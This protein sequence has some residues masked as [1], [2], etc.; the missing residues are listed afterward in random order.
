MCVC[1]HVCL[2]ID[3]LEVEARLYRIPDVVN[4]H[5]LH[6]WNLSSQTVAM[7]VHIQV[8]Q[9]TDKKSNL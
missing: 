7:T 3:W 5:D 9:I 1:V 4:V 2:Q 6:L 8:Q